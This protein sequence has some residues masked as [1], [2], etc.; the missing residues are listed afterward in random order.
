MKREKRIRKPRM[1][2]LIPD[3]ERRAEIL[4][5]MYKGD[6]VVGQDGIFTDLL[7][8]MVDAALEGE[9]DAHLEDERALGEPKS[10]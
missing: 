3:P 7:Q 9:M 4:S 10:P 8:A 5:R 6:P 2:D 1:E